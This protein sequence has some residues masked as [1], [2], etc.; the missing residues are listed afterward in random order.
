MVREPKKTYVAVVEHHLLRRRA[1]VSGALADDRDGTPRGDADL[2]RRGAG[3]QDCGQNEGDGEDAWHG[4]VAAPRENF[5]FACP[6]DSINSINR[7]AQGG[8]GVEP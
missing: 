6:G 5:A 1:A 7:I 4:C 2:I 3:Q 8:K